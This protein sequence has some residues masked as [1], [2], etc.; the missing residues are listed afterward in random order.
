MKNA[1]NFHS[2]SFPVQNRY[3]N[4]KLPMWFFHKPLSVLFKNEK[5]NH[6]TDTNHLNI[7]KVFGIAR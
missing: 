1:K 7:I 4:S 5:E 6:L 2:S 3:W